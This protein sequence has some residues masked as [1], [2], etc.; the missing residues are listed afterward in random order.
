MSEPLEPV[1]QG[2]Q[3]PS[4]KSPDPAHFYTG[5]NENENK[6]KNL[7]PQPKPQPELNVTIQA[8]QT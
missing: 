5:N 4:P 6:N 7:E 1:D 2:Q 8:L 3:I